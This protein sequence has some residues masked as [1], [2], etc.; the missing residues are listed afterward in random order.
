[1]F[2]DTNGQPVRI[3]GSA[4]TYGTNIIG[5]D[6]ALANVAYVDGAI[7]QTLTDIAIRK[8]ADGNTQVEVTDASDATGLSR[9]DFLMDSS[10]IST[11]YPDKIEL[12]DLRISGQTISGTVSN[13]DIVLDAPGTGTV[14]INDVLQIAQ[15]PGT[16]D[17]NIDPLA[18]TDGVKLYSKSEGPGN[19]GLYFVNTNN[20]Q[21]ELISRKKALIL[22]YLL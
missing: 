7:S 21:D 5:V 16:D 19:T 9:I 8:I 10:I 13:G 3:V 22:G 4:V 14:K 2:I 1:M 12:N 11:F 17:P 6:E 15:T 20:T 18:P